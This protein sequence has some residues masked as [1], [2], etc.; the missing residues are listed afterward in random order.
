MDA[1]MPTLQILEIV[2]AF[3]RN[4]DGFTHTYVRPLLTYSRIKK[5]RHAAQLDKKVARPAPAAPICSP[6][7]RIKIGSRRMFRRHPLIVPMLA[8]KEEPSALTRYAR[9][10]FRMA[11]T[12]PQVTVHFKYSPVAAA[13][14]ASAPSTSKRG[15]R[16]AVNRME[17]TAPL[18][19]AQ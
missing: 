7:G 10:T 14:P 3:G 9:T 6:Q 4:I 5:Y 16:K 8:C 2:D 12:A 1:G 18:S 19:S 17:N 11:G 15:C 13:V